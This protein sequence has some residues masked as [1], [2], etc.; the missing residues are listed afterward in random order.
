MGSAA[1]PASTVAS[2]SFAPIFAVVAA[3]QLIPAY[4]Y[5]RNLSRR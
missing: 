3:V 4:F 1:D 5:F 2:A